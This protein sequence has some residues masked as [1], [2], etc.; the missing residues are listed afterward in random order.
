MS[1]LFQK[2][3]QMHKP[4]RPMPRAYLADGHFWHWLNRL[5][6]EELGSL[7]CGVWPGI[8]EIYDFGNF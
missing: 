8:S 1:L 7:D 6:R 2:F 5:F 4:I 3:D